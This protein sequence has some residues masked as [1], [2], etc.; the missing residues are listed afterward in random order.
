MEPL[1]HES[2]GDGGSDAPGRYGGHGEVLG[3][4]FSEESHHG[5]GDATDLHPAFQSGA[6]LLPE[7]IDAPP[8]FEVMEDRFDLPAV[9]VEGDDFAGCQVGFGSEIEASGRPS[10][11]LFVVDCTPYGPDRMAFQ[12]SCV[13]DDGLETDLL[14][15]PVDMQRDDLGG[16][17]GY[18]FRCDL[19][20]I[21]PGASALGG[22]RWRIPEQRRIFAYLADELA[23]PTQQGQEKAPTHEP[24]IGEETDGYWDMGQ[25][26]AQQRP[27]DFQLVGVAGAGHEAQADGEGDRFTGSGTEGQ[28]QTH[29]ILGEDITGT[30]V[31]MAVVKADSRTWGFGRVSQD[32][33]IVDDE[34]DDQELGQGLQKPANLGYG[35][36]LGAQGLALQEFVI[37]GPVAAEGDATEG[38]GDPAFWRDQA[39]T[40]QFEEAAP[41]AGRHDRQKVGNPLRQAEGNE[42]MKGHG[43]DSEKPKTLLIGR[44]FFTRVGRTAPSPCQ[45]LSPEERR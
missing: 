39:A 27:G 45:A 22:S 44:P 33:G 42:T 35:Q 2:C 20:P 13:S 30:I 31:L 1:G 29:P 41:R 16:Q 5:P 28:R 26:S 4:S 37:G 38:A 9:A 7:I 32:Q 23:V 24:G 40:E 12:E 14:P 11:M 25:K 6:F 34:I 15:F 8:A 19:V 17:C 10:T 3:G 18:V 43:C 21:Y 36:R